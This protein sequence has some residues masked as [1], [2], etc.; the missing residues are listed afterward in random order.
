MEQR[1]LIRRMRPEDIAAAAALEQSCFSEPWSEQNFSDELKNPR[2]MFFVAEEHGRP[3]GHAGLH[4]VLD[5]GYVANVAVDP[6]ARQRGVGHAL[7]DALCTFAQAQLLRF[8]TLEVRESNLPAIALYQKHGF[9]R[10]GRRKDFYAV[11]TEDAI[12]MTKFFNWKK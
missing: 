2:G 8:L 9:E 12:L 1:L 10:V 11:P 6:S 7:V 4:H 3:I 5:E